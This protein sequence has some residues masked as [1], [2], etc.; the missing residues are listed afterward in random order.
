MNKCQ[1]FGFDLLMI[2][3][4]IIF[5]SQMI[6]TTFFNFPKDYFFER[7]I[8]NHELLR[9]VLMQ[10]NSLAYFDCFMAFS[11]NDCL[12][13]F[14]DSI[15]AS[16]NAYLVN[17]NYV[18]NFCGLKYSNKDYDNLCFTKA[19]PYYLNISLPNSNCEIYFSIYTDG[20]VIDCA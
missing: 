2:I 15:E 12:K 18:L 11:S 5:F 4:A 6:F 8:E 10:N 17:R 16:L 7:N 20:E 3:I 13:A 9:A 14:N 19:I 1:S